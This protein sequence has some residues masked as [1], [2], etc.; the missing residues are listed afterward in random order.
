MNS[1]AKTKYG[2]SDNEG[3][4]ILGGR[5]NDNA[6]KSDDVTSDEEPPASEE[7][8][9]TSKDSV[10]ERERKCTGDIR[11]GD[12]V[13][14]TNVLID[15]A[16]NIGWKDDEEVSANSCEAESLWPR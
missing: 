14:R 15:V 11:P 16:Q 8:G 10:S 13:A 3:I 2:G 7:I 6:D 4:H 5:G 12:V 1:L 9:K